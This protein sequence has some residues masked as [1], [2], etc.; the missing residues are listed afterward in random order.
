MD[1]VGFDYILQ[2]LGQT[3]EH[4]PQVS[5]GAIIAVWSILALTRAGRRP[6]NEIELLSLIFGSLCILWFFVH[7]WVAYADLPWLDGAPPPW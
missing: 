5:S 4:A 1:D 2:R 6:S 3:L 7:Y